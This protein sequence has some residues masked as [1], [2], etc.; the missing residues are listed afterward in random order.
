MK[1]TARA[2]RPPT[3]ELP[4]DVA[5]ACG[6]FGLLS[7]VLSVFLAYF[8]GLAVTLSIL[9]VGIGVLR[10]F[11]AG[12]AGGPG[13]G[14]AVVT[15]APMAIGWTMFAVAPGPFARFRGLA[16]GIS[17]VPLWWAV[18]RPRAFGGMG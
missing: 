12:A 17:L 13:R 14:T 11:G 4:M 6:S 18:R 9:A 5:D 2:A 16:L 1:R 10:L 8:V 15:L 7:G 3:P